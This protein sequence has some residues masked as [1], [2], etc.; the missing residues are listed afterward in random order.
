MSPEGTEEIMIISD[1]LQVL[2]DEIHEPLDSGQDVHTIYEPSM[3]HTHV[4]DDKPD[5][6]TL[7]AQ[8]VTSTDVASNT[9]ATSPPQ[10]KFSRQPSDDCAIDAGCSAGLEVKDYPSRGYLSDNCPFGGGCPVSDGARVPDL[11][12]IVDSLACKRLD[13]ISMAKAFPE[14]MVNASSLATTIDTV[15]C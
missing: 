5:I 1:S 2:P 15:L 9:N 7:V 10:I 6:A 13:A 14:T 4:I 3:V 11:Q 12:P 8:V